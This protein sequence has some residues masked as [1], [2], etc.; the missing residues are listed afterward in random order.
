MVAF[1]LHATITSVS[2]LLFAPPNLSTVKL[3][4][5]YNIKGSSSLRMDNELWLNTLSLFY[6]LNNK[7][8]VKFAFVDYTWEQS[9]EP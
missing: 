9:S 2:C 8:G 1:F 5:S 3:D 4:G 6:L 7:P